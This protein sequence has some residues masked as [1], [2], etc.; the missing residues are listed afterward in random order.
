MNSLQVNIRESTDDDNLAMSSIYSQLL[1]LGTGSLA[2]AP[3]SD[4]EIGRCKEDAAES[5]CPCF[6]AEVQGAIVGFAYAEK[7]SWE[8]GY[9]YT[10]K[11]YVY[12]HPEAQG[13]GVAT[14]LLEALIAECEARGFRQ[15]VNFVCD[16]KNEAAVNLHKKV[17][18]KEIGRMKS[19]G[20]K[21]DE[22]LDTIVMQRPLGAGDA[23]KPNLEKK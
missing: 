17:G 19:I 1:A 18:F 11:D 13:E 10:V 2:D 15:M 14:Q 4:E 16:A 12:V 5:G 21:F 9:R 23:A 3:P 7:F 22:W 20:F 6:V 8:K